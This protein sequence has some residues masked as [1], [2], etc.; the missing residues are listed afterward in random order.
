MTIRGCCGCP[1]L[2]S[3]KGF[4]AVV[5]YLSFLFLRLRRPLWLFFHLRGIR[6]RR[7]R[8]RYIFQYQQMVFADVSGPQLCRRGQLFCQIVHQEKF[9][10][11]I[12][13]LQL[14]SFARCHR[15][16][17]NNLRWR[18]CP[19]LANLPVPCFSSRVTGLMA[20]VGHTWP[21]ATQFS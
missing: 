3:F 21:Q 18:I 13:H 10:E 8:S 14:F 4:L 6:V 12:Y 9:E 20:E 16:D 7:F 19:A 11:K 1:P 2:F 5:F 15:Q 17:S